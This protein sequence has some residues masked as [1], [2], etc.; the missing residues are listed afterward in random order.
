MKPKLYFQ[1]PVA[2]RSGYGD[3]A[4]EIARALLELRDEFDIKFISMP[5]GQCP[6]DA[7]EYDDPLYITIENI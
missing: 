3:R 1:S 5:W 2:T 7:L 6:V 4:R